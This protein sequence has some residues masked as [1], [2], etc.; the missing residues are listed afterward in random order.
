MILPDKSGTDADHEVVKLPARTVRQLLIA[1]V[2]CFALLLAALF[3]Y[4]L[5]IRPQSLTFDPPAMT[6][7]PMK[8]PLIVTD[9]G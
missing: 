1:G 9:R 8:A 3:G 7:E 2:I 4:R 6:A 5:Q